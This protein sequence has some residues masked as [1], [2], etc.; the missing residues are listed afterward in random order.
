[1]TT[2]RDLQTATASGRPPEE[3]CARLAVLRD[4]PMVE[5]DTCVER[6]RV[7]MR[8]DGPEL[9]SLRSECMVSAKA[10]GEAYACNQVGHPEW[11]RPTAFSTSQQHPEPGRPDPG[12]FVAVRIGATCLC[13]AA[14]IAL[15]AWAR[16]VGDRYP[17]PRFV[18]LLAYVFL[19]IPLVDAGLAIRALT[20][21]GRRARGDWAAKTLADFAP[22]ALTLAI[23]TLCMFAVAR[24]YERRA[25]KEPTAHPYRRPARERSSLR[26]RT[27]R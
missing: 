6:M 9:W 2:A 25:R 8:L 14:A 21:L 17:S 11:P 26:D 20:S 7:A 18:G 1:M 27:A 12:T 3:V 4:H 23:A 16:R 13:L 5:D 22:T 15:A 19:A 10:L 24:R